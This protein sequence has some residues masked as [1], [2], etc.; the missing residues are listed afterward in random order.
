M[1]RSWCLP[2]TYA[3]KIEGVRNGTITQTIR[4]G[5][6]FHAGDVVMFHGW[7]GRPYYSAWTLRTPFFKIIEVIN[8]DFGEQ[9]VINRGEQITKARDFNTYKQLPFIS[10]WEELDWLAELDG[11]E[12]P[13]GI[14]LKEI[15][16]NKNG[17]LEGD[18]QII[19]WCHTDVKWKM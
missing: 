10:K 19:R 13:T 8:C 11:I 5:V 9:G 2:L 16:K 6:K 15:L 17:K 12:P 7:K 1:S 14:A 18:Y 4:K 3:P